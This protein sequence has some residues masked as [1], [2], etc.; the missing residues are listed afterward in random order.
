MDVLYLIERETRR[1]GYSPRTT[2]TYICCVRK[3]MKWAK[4][5]PRRITRQDIQEYIDRL[6]DRNRSGSTINVYVNAIK[7]LMQ[8]IL[9]KRVFLRVKFSKVPKRLPA[10][11]S[12]DE[13]RRLIDA[14]ENPTHKLMIELMYSAGL[15]V[16]ELVHLRA[17]DIFFDNNLGWVRKGKGGKD[18]LFIIAQ[19]IKEKLKGHIEKNCPSPDSWVFPGRK[20]RSLS[21]RVPQETVKEAARKTGIS[22]VKEIHC[23]TLRH[24]FATHLIENGNSVMAVQQLLGHSD[25]DTTMVY[26]HIASPNMIQVKSPYD[27]I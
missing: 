21:I 3:F 7:F 23:H 17:K 26:V 25:P 22:R 12:K 15:R 10:V 14:I 24:S 16:S 20:G 11:L 4:K 27:G 13:V 8:D 6:V 5:E 9:G 2:E 1:R 18:R 19:R